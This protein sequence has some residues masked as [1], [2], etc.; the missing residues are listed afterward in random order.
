MKKIKG[1][2][3]E[4]EFEDLISLNREQISCFDFSKCK[5]TD[6]DV[7]VTITKWHDEPIDHTLVG[8]VGLLGFLCGVVLG[9]AVIFYCLTIPL[10]Q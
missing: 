6:G 10:G 3:R 8:L 1:Y 2:M 4:H 7:L 9:F 5:I